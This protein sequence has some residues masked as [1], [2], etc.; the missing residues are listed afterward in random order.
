MRACG[1]SPRLRGTYG[2]GVSGRSGVRFI[3]APAG[4]MANTASRLLLVTVHPRACGEHR[5]WPTTKSLQSGSS[6]RLRGTS[7][8]LPPSR[9]LRRF[10][11]APAGNMSSAS[12]RSC[13]P[14]VHPRACG[15]HPAA[16]E[17]RCGAV[18][19]SPRLR[20]TSYGLPCRRLGSRFIPAPAGNIGNG[21]VTSNNN[22]VHPRACGEHM[23]C[24][25][26][27]G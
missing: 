22:A 10:I 8:P 12:S 17:T 24:G 1:S 13:G 15:E 27:P 20:G 11:P 25:P 23:T 26:W 18:G 3:P 5:P 16:G 7:V 9:W 19:S 2:P 21:I 14:S 4:N 6:P